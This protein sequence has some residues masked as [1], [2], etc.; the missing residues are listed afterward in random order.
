[1]E[2]PSL[3]ILR[4]ELKPFVGR[5]VLS[6]S[7]NTK[8]P[9]D[10]L[11]GRTLERVETWGKVLFLF[12]T[13]P[14]GQ[15]PIMTKTHFLMFGSYRID[16]PKPARDPRLKLRF[17]NG[18]VYFYSCSIRFD[19]EDYYQA[20][21]RKVDLLGDEWDPRHVLR[22]LA[23][24]RSTALCD[25]FLEQSVFAGSGNIVKNE[26]L[27]NL[28]EHPMTTLGQIP[29]SDWPKLI[30][31][32]HRYCENFYEWKK[33]FELRRHWQVYRQHRCPLCGEKIVR[34]TT[35]KMARKSFYCANHQKLRGRV[36][37]L[38]VHAVLPMR[39]PKAPVERRLDH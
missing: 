22:L 37:A 29:V 33:K 28:R 4:E 8:Q 34:E 11:R 20:L 39:K 31:A 13:K 10:E 17:A 21:D 38:K 16:D 3:V 7:G 12:F 35:G 1:M 36:H 27:F 25:L 23:K 9:K 5:R 32:V 26:V 18:T 6:V 15:D 14:R 30:R 24:K 2:G 19:A